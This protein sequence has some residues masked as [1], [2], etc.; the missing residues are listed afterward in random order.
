MP[1]MK[2]NIKINDKNNF[3][4]TSFFWLHINLL[5][6]TFSIRGCRQ[7]NRKGWGRGCKAPFP[8]GGGGM[9]H[10]PPPPPK[11]KGI[12]IYIYSQGNAISSILGIKKSAWTLNR[13]SSRSPGYRKPPA[14]PPSPIIETPTITAHFNWANQKKVN[15]STSQWEFE[16]ETSKLCE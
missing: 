9:V 4:S 3:L 2:N 11:K 13:R 12:Y 8:K 10:K 1:K 14:I 5:L 6:I 15:I 7:C 16:V